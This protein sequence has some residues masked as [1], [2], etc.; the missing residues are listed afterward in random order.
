[1]T[2]NAVEH[3]VQI[4]STLSTPDALLKA[5]LQALQQKRSELPI[6][7]GEKTTPH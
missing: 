3:S 2:L 7:R 5:D 6:F 4:R 1:L